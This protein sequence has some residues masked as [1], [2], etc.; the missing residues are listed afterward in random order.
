MSK[1]NGIALLHRYMS[2]FILLLMVL[3]LFGATG[4][5]KIKHL[6]ASQLV[7]EQKVAENH[8]EM[9][10]LV[11]ELYESQIAMDGRIQTFATQQ[12]VLQQ[13]ITRS[14][15]YLDSLTQDL[16]TAHDKLQATI[17]QT[18]THQKHITTSLTSLAE[19]QSALSRR[20]SGVEDASEALAV[21]VSLANE[22][23]CVL[24][25]KVS[26]NHAQV[27]ASVKKVTNEQ[28]QLDTEFSQFQQE[29]LLRADQLERI[30][31]NYETLQTQAEAMNTDLA[32]LQ[33][34]LDS[35]TKDVL[36]RLTVH[37]RERETLRQNMQEVS[38]KLATLRTDH[39]TLEQHVK[40]VKVTPDPKVKP[41]D[42]EPGI[43]PY[44]FMIDP[45][46]VVE[47]T[48]VPLKMPK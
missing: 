16:S 24:L 3:V 29:S 31:K 35:T 20:I 42:E 38:S 44:S 10:A 2:K 19:N 14:D 27:T 1:K 8:A 26:D 48:K 12:G 6:E 32:A 47:E 41:E 17:T 22:D 43:E 7:L 15:E 40:A 46:F 18:N 23:H 4:C 33:K 37:R 9:A 13:R 11:E 25:Q 45:E 5:Q 21:S 39:S 34:T 36:S 28:G 30:K